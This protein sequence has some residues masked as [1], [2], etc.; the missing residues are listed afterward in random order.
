MA[1]KS[2]TVLLADN[3]RELCQILA[4]HIEL[5]DDME[6][7]GIAYD[8][9]E[10]LNLVKERKP[11]VLVLDITMPYLDGIGV[12]E[13]L[14]EIS[15][16]PQVIVLTAFEQESMVQRMIAMGA[17]YYVVKPFDTSALLSRIRQFGATEE[18]CLKDG[19]AIFGFESPNENSEVGSKLSLELE[20]TRLFHEMGIPA[21]FRGYAYLRD[22][23]ILA[24]KE[25]DILAN[26]TKNLYPRIAE[27]YKS[28]TSGV[29]SAIRHTIEIGWERGNSDF[30][31]KLFGLGEG[32]DA[33]AKF[34]TA[35]S[36]IAK[37]AEKI[38]LQLRMSG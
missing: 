26:I 37:V 9:L 18:E 31:K 21:H 19:K 27:K 8:G 35:A 29:E 3:N 13:R 24:V 33:R 10:A 17:V 25:A 36:F 38:R 30:F 12:M 14:S 22:S 6:L 11:D 5:Q 1:E 34:P 28:T 7:I 2:I 4:E 16:P 20:V 32:L 15:S 23:I